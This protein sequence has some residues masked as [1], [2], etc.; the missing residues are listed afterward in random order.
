MRRIRRYAFI[1][2]G[3]ALLK[4]VYHL[5]GNMLLVAGFEF[6]KAHVRYFCPIT[7]VI[8]LSLQHSN[9]NKILYGEELSFEW[10][11]LST[12]LG[13]SKRL[14]YCKW[15]IIIYMLIP[16][17]CFIN[18]SS[19]LYCFS[20]LEF[21]VLNYLSQIFSQISRISSNYHE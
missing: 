7:V 5:E 13:P 17:Y 2:L 21:I 9:S 3:L 12:W 1:G 16:E 4:E 8:K 11:I 18:L 15:E 20:N 14:T 19:I 6:S 10:I